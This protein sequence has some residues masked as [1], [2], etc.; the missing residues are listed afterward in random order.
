M[1]DDIRLNTFPH[2]KKAAIAYLFVKNQDLTNKSVTEIM[3][4][5]EKAYNELKLHKID[6]VTLGL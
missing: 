5:Y 6:P 1:G 3:D 2:N 4:F